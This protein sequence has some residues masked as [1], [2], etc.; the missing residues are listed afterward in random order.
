M[1]NSAVLTKYILTLFFVIFAYPTSNLSLIDNNSEQGNAII[2]TPL[3][4]PGIY[5]Q[6]PGNCLPAGPSTYLTQL[7]QRGMSLPLAPLPAMQADPSLAQ[8]DMHYGQIVNNNAPVFATVDDASKGRRQ[9]AIEQINAEFAYIAYKEDMVI[10]G[11]RFYNTDKGWMTAN[12]VSRIGALPRFQGLVFS[13]TPINSFGWVLGYL[14]PEP[15]QTKRTPGYK[16]EDYTGHQ[17]NDYDVVQIYGEEQVDEN[18]WYMVGPDE[19]VP[20]RVIARVIP[21]TN[22]PEGLT[23]DRWIEVNLYEQTLAVYDQ[24]KLVFATLIASG[25]EPFWTKPG[26]F[27]IYE[28]HEMTPMRGA[29]S[30]DGSNG[31][32][33]EAVPWTMYFDEAR[34]LHGAYWRAKL[35]FQQSHGCINL[36]VGDAHWLFNWANTGD[37]V[38]VWDPSGQTPTD[39]SL[40]T[41]GGY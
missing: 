24:R 33:L 12:D 38:Y 36:T 3:C 11:K 22:P 13:R 18:T 41:S 35:G 1:K 4:L 15:V 20:E 14:N 2:S 28:K 40:Y 27:Q 8:I 9:N 7:G 5:L 17:L 29:F 37:F 19:W 10:N 26:L 16:G 21:M 34:A 39:P 25:A 30:A 6:D 32:Y 31:Y 23:G